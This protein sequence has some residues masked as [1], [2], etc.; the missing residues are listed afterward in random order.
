M[1]VLSANSEFPSRE[2]RNEDAGEIAA[3]QGELGRQQPN[4]SVEISGSSIAKRN[5]EHG[6]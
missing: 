1:K 6:I 5:L 2:Q 3:K 4:F